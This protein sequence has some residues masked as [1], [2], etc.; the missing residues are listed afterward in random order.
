MKVTKKFNDALNNDDNKN[1][2]KLVSGDFPPLHHFEEKH[3]ITNKTKKK[4]KDAK[5]NPNHILKPDIINSEYMYPATKVSDAIRDLKDGKKEAV[6]IDAGIELQSSFSGDEMVRFWNSRVKPTYRVEVPN[7]ISDIKYKTYKNM[8]NHG[9][10]MWNAYATS[11]HDTALDSPVINTIFTEVTGTDKW[12]ITPNRI[13]YNIPNMSKINNEFN[14]GGYSSAHIEGEHV[15]SESS[16]ISCIVCITSNRSFTFYKGSNN[17]S[18]MRDIFTEAMERPDFNNFEQPTQTDLTDFERTTIY[19]TRPGQIIL[20]A[21]SVVH[22][23]SKHNESLSL[24][25]SPYNPIHVQNENI[26]YDDFTKEEALKIRK[27]NMLKRPTGLRTIP[28][29][30]LKFRMPGILKQHPKEFDNLTRY[31]TDVFGSLFHIGGSHWPSGKETYFMH[32]NQASGAHL[33]KYL[34]FCFTNEREWLKK[35]SKLNSQY[36][37]DY[38]DTLTTNEEKVKYSAELKKKKSEGKFIIKRKFNYELITPNLVRNCDDFD[39]KT[40]FDNLPLAN[41]LDVEIATMKV[42]Y[43]GI[44]NIAWPLIKYWTK[45]PRKCSDQVAYRRGYIK[46]FPRLRKNSDDLDDYEIRYIVDKL[47]EDVKLYKNTCNIQRPFDQL[48]L[49]QTRN[50]DNEYM[51]DINELRQLLNDIRE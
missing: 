11:M 4:S 34:P 8:P 38:V 19:T 23:I 49:V 48:S 51:N 14:D 10:G 28:V 36:V 50:I 5:I 24:F 18:S 47:I 26:Y 27:L 3:S 25:L 41:I 39:G 37:C 21:D 42:K 40:Y 9:T 31:E 16:G 12:K 30:P 32:H 13:R 2:G 15:L 22:E 35:D 33:K 6:I 29:L 46:T 1:I 17:N 44:P 7:T 45:D 20:F 43:D